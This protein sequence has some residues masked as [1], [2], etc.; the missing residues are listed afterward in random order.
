[1]GVYSCT[2]PMGRKELQA[3]MLGGEL[4]MCGELAS[5]STFAV[6]LLSVSAETLSL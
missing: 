5:S 2:G 1:M 4:M 6:E 3:V